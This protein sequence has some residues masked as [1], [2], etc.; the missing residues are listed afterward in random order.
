M[1]R[2]FGDFMLKDHGIIAIPEISYRPLTSSDQFVVL[3]SD[4]VCVIW[5]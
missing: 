4:G 3:A 5:L 2:A 1:S